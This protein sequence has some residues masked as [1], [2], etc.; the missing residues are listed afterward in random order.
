MIQ[1]LQEFTAKATKRQQE[2]DFT[3][4]AM[5][6]QHH[7]VVLN[8]QRTDS[9]FSDLDGLQDFL[10]DT[11][12]IASDLDAQSTSSSVF[13]DG[14]A[15]LRISREPSEMYPRPGQYCV[16]ESD[17][18]VID[19]QHLEE[20]GTI[21]RRQQERDSAC[22]TPPR[23]LQSKQG[24][25]NPFAKLLGPRTAH[26]Y[27]LE[28]LEPCQLQFVALL[29]RLNND[30]ASLIYELENENFTT[31]F[32]VCGYHGFD[33]ALNV[34][35]ALGA[36]LLQIN[37]QDVDST[38][39]VQELEK[40]LRELGPRATM[41][42]RN[43]SWSKTQKDTLQMAI[44]EQELLHPEASSSHQQINFVNPFNRI[45]SQSSDS[46]TRPGIFGKWNFPG[47]N[48]SSVD[49]EKPQS[50]TSAFKEVSQR[51][52]GLFRSSTG[53]D[54]LGTAS[55]PETKFI[56]STTVEYNSSDYNDRR[57]PSLTGSRETDVDVVS[58]Q[59]NVDNDTADQLTIPES[60]GDSQQ[61]GS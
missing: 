41:T 51:G 39:T 50:I 49:A 10:P 61:L 22:T 38:W 56:P 16:S 52:S 4:L 40:H 21:S 17:N 23:I 36:R 31:A 58:E 29:V 45:R 6:I 30:D 19:P 26:P 9:N 20:L 5:Q 43:D 3:K 60:L 54:A 1:Q 11:S 14:I 8:R 34:K 42:F 32:A 55:T 37:K 7:E 57:S 28:F 12:S 33:S 25:Q 53:S 46:A 47:T 15:T 2:D 24:N 44:Q 18:V 27:T 59:T 48:R 13:D 35:P